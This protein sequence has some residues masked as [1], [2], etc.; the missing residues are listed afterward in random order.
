MKVYVHQTQREKLITLLMTKLSAVRHNLVLT[1][2]PKALL[3]LASK[4]IISD[5][6][7]ISEV[8]YTELYVVTE[9]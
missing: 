8:I 6:T 3:L 1:V 7:A 9:N 4:Q 5:L 2:G